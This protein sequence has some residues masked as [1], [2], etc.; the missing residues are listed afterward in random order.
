M[1]IE[2]NGTTGITTPGLINTGTET[3]VNLTTTGNTILGDASTDTLNVGNGGLVKDA[4]GNVG[5][6]TASPAVKLHAYSSGGEPARFES[7]LSYSLATVK[8]TSGSTFWGINGDGGLLGTSSAVPLIFKPND[9]ERMRLDSS[10]NLGLGVTPSAWGSSGNLQINSAI[11]SNTNTFALYANGYYSG[12]AGDKY[13]TTSTASRYYQLAGEHVWNTAPSGT[14]G[15]TITFTTPMQLKA[16]GRLGLGT[17]DPN[18]RL[19][20]RQD[21]ATA[22]SESNIL[23][24]NYTSGTTPYYIGGLFGAAYRDVRFPAYCAGIDFYRTSAAGGLASAGEIRFYTDGNG[25]TQA[26]LRTAEK[27]RLDASGNLL[28]GGTARVGQEKLLIVTNNPQ[29]GLTVFSNGGLSG[30]GYAYRTTT[31]TGYATYFQTN[32]TTV[33]GW[34]FLTGTTTAYSTSSDYRL[35]DNV[36]PMTGALDKVALLKPVT[37]NWKADGSDGQGFIAHEL[38]EIVPECVS[39]EKDA[40][41][42]EEYEISPAI[43]AVI[44]EEGKEVTPAVEA[45][46]GT[47][48][49]P[50][51][52]GIDTSFLVATLTAAIQEQQAMIDELKAKVAALE[53][54]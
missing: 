49:V 23:M 4:S 5:I 54:A 34:I 40:T 15:G 25:G 24:F 12:G 8:S 13:I 44:D 32:S 30:A 42:E 9:T 26:E 3:I 46:M 2:L 22:G 35:K 20:L 18:T 27:M 51:Y 45:V 11:A 50:V 33:A 21:T 41:K 14:A 19:E 53:A 37:Y 31:N 16:N 39:G 29:D 38:G 6:G 10:G 7:S 36:A 17:T 48:T 28:I 43:P 47:R 1:A 52:Q